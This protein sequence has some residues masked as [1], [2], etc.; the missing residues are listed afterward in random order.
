MSLSAGDQ[1]AVIVG[2]QH[3]FD[4]D[5]TGWKGLD[6]NPLSIGSRDLL[7]VD[8]DMRMPFTVDMCGPR[9]LGGENEV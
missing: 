8:V 9:A 4:L 6:V 7:A 1:C 2:V 3:D 5:R